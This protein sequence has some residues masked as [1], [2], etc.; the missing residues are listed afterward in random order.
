MK[1][2]GILIY[3]GPSQWDKRPIVVIITGIARK[4][5]NPKTGDMLQAWILR[6]DFH[7]YAALDSSICGECIHRPD[8]DG[9]RS[10]YVSMNAPGAVWKA[11]KAGKYPR[12][13]PTEAGSVIVGHCVR[14]GAY[15]DPAMVPLDV[16]RP[17]VRNAKSTTGYTHQWK[18]MSPEYREFCMASV[19]NEAETVEAQA[20]GYRTFRCVTADQSLLD[21]EIVCP[22]SEEAGKLTTCNRCGL[23]EGEIK[24][25]NQ[26]PSIAIT[27]HGRG[28]RYFSGD[29]PLNKEVL[30]TNDS[31]AVNVV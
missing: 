27:V 1:P 16:W 31:N 20:L 9:H 11:Y 19:D 10:C 26:I 14:L 7:P 24:R 5:R 17:I 23:C 13:T 12:L 29:S 6:Q 4:S 30:M 18:H 21:N 25:S 28:A 2:N 8:E 3:E 22:A 15:G